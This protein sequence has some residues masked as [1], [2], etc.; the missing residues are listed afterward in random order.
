MR[1]L[2]VLC[3]LAVLVSSVRADEAAQLFETLY[4]KKIKA[5]RST[6]TRSDDVSLAQ[7]LL[8]VARTSTDQSSLLAILCD[9]AY[10]LGK[11]RA[12]GYA[13][14]ID[15][16]QLLAEH[17]D[18]RKPEAQDRIVDL[19]NRQIRTSDRDAAK[20]AA[21]TMTELLVTIGEEQMKAKQFSDA[22]KSFQRAL[23][24]A[25]R[26]K[27]AVV[28]EIKQQTE[29][30][31][32]AQR[33]HVEIATLRERLLRD[34]N[35]TAAAK[36]LV[37]LY[38]VELNDIQSASHYVAQTGDQTLAAYVNASTKPVEQASESACYDLGHW[39]HGLAGKGSRAAKPVMLG[40]AHAYLSRY[41]AL[42]SSADLKRK[43][44]EILVSQIEASLAA[45]GSN[46]NA[47][48]AGG[49]MTLPSK[50]VLLVTFEKNHIAT[51][52]MK[53]HVKDLSGRNFHGRMEA[54]SIVDGQSGSAL[55]LDG[56]KT[57]VLFNGRWD[58]RRGITACLWVKFSHHK[59]FIPRFYLAVTDTSSSKARDQPTDASAG[60]CHRFLSIMPR[61]P[62]SI[63]RSN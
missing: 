10:E 57:T 48:S 41:L 34:A 59:K 46:T 19:L 18:E 7:Q 27:L 11:Q 45:D 51:I 44:A 52:G 33:T 40:R 36:S 54:A 38:V 4:G 30:A 21:E 8:T 23:I 9:N 15:A 28:A 2:F 31:K 35:D 62:R 37:Q 47:N 13:T 63:V 49:R 6:V 55:E 61:K 25:S 26:H 14:A 60:V 3:G 39:Y 56:Q 12:D 1:C 43:S 16:M 32:Q 22:A 58:F 20:Q 53:T 24:V 5:V 42:H 29:S 17:D 50:P